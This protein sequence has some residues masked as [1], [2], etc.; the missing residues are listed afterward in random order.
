[1]KIIFGTL[2]N[3]GKSIKSRRIT[4]LSIVRNGSWLMTSP[5]VALGRGLSLRE[6][7]SIF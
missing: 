7:Q 1:M 3:G 4:I 5:S 6:V 2:A